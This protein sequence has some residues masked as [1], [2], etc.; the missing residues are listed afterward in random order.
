MQTKVYIPVPGNDCASNSD[1]GSPTPY[2]DA[3]FTAVEPISKLVFGRHAFPSFLLFRELF[4]DYLQTGTLPEMSAGLAMG[5]T[6]RS[7]SG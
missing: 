4:A 7:H 6:T 2:N 3:V 1:T 5:D